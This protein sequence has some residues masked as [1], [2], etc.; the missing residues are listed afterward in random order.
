MHGGADVTLGQPKSSLHKRVA[1][2][3]G[4]GTRKV[5]RCM[6]PGETERFL[7][8]FA[9]GTKSSMEKLPLLD[10]GSYLR[11]TQKDHLGK[12]DKRKPQIRRRTAVGVG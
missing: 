5:R 10:A 6:P 2:G 3:S 11:L 8:L 7:C 4:A 9:L 1:V 12:H